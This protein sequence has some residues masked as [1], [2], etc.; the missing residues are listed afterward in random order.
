[1]DRDENKSCKRGG[2]NGL[3]T[4]VLEEVFGAK[5]RVSLPGEWRM[6]YARQVFMKNRRMRQGRYPQL[7]AIR[8]IIGG[9]ME[10]CA[11]VCH[12]T[13]WRFASALL[14]QEQEDAYCADICIRDDGVL[15]KCI[16]T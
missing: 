4:C 8:G 7:H 15:R 9:S 6:T 16:R 11:S 5:R 14:T 13:P 3:T 12:T 1:M 10:I 2:S